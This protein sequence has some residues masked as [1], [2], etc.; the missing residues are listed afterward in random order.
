MK[1]KSILQSNVNNENN[2]SL[3]QCIVDY[4]LIDDALRGT[5]ANLVQVNCVC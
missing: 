3:L 1:A 5:E 4:L 2:S